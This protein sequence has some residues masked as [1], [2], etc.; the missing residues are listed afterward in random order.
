MHARISLAI[1]MAALF[2]N[3]DL[4][5]A[6]ERPVTLDT[7]VVIGERVQPEAVAKPL[8]IVNSD[9][10]S[11]RQASTLG[12]TLRGL[13]GVSA[14][15]FGPNSSRP[16]IRGQDGDRVKILQNSAPTNDASAM[17]F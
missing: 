1:C 8:S 10:L 11:R 9:E 5:N 4:V 7:V 12:E 3:A 14:S 13:P 6:Q 15:G 16:V 2:A 17:S